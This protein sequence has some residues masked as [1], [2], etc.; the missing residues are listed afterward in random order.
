MERFSSAVLDASVVI[1]W[2][3]R[4]EP[5]C[6]KAQSL[7]QRFLDG[8]LKISV[9]ELLLYEIAN[10]LRYKPDLSEQDVERAVW[11]VLEMEITEPIPP[12]ILLSAISLAYKHNITYYDAIYLSLAKEL[13]YS[14]VTADRALYERTER[15]SFVYLLSQIG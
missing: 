14:F 5:D 2:F 7:R 1:K 11:S 6:E 4:L 8:G 3:R 12:S 10:V 15:M 9:P 13:G